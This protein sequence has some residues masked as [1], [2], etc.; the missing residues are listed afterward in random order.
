MQPVNLKTLA[1]ELNLA[2]S[3]VSRA[4]RDSYD[5]S[6]KTKERVLAAAKKY[7]YEPN[8]YASSLR[9]RQS[10]TIAVVIPD[11]SNNFFSLAINGIEAIAQEK[12]YHVLIYLTHEDYE[13][14]KDILKLLQNGRVDGILLSVSGNTKDAGH[15]SEL[16]KNN[17]PVVFFDRIAESIDAPKVSTNDYECG[18]K[19]TE[20]LI[21]NG[22]TNIAHLCISKDLS[23]T[24]NRLQGYLDALKNYNLKLK[25]EMVIECDT[26]NNS[27]KY[28]QIYAL[29]NQ[30]NKP[31]GIFASIES[32]AIS[33]YEICHELNLAIPDDVKIISFSNLQTAQ[34]LKPSLTTITQPAFEIGRE[35]ATILFKRLEKKKNIQTN[36]TVVI[37]SALIARESTKKIS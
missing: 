7:N 12:K 21:L 8:P 22:C 16:I 14:E 19:A 32:L 9:K 24:N 18:Y 3:T 29:L 13:K 33:A 23:I 37:D 27:K 15:I 31:N 11:V 34:L 5:I 6:S 36:E 20:H 1:K 17:I 25:K 4:L 2:H 26:Y 10:K 30:K 35:A 28:Q